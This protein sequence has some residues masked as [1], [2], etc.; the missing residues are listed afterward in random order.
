MVDI[1]KQIEEMAVPKGEE[2]HDSRVWE[3]SRRC[4]RLDRS[5]WEWRY[6]E[7][8]AEEYHGQVRG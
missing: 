6:Y 2:D 8:K 7:R 3:V 5:G 4:V 1:C